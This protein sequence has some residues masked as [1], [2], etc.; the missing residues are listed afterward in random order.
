MLAYYKENVK[1]ME[2][3]EDTFKWCKANGIKVAT[4]TGFHRDINSAIMEG[5]GWLK[6]GLIDFSVNVEDTNGVGRPAPYM[7]FRAME[8]L[9][10]Q[11]VHEVIK[12]GDTPADLLSGKISGAQ[13]TLVC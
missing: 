1:A 4:D 5:L 3:A 9:G 7:V 10:I 6:D 2:G 12:I 11:S 8:A 13:E